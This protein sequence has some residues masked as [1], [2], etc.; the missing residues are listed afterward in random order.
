MGGTARAEDSQG[1]PTQSHISPNI[2]VYEGNKPSEMDQIEAGACALSLHLNDLI[3]SLICVGLGALSEHNFYGFKIPFCTRNPLEGRL[4]KHDLVWDAPPEARGSHN[5]TLHPT[6]YTLHPT[7]Y[8][9]HP[10]PYT[11]H[12]TP[13]T[14]HHAPYTL[15][16][17]P[18]T[19]SPRT[20]KRGTSQH[21]CGTSA[22][23]CNG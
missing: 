17:T 6:P 13:F 9:L 14:L 2:L 8:T 11:L 19:L 22:N 16:P 4:A 7:P 15:H 1:T 21:K 12:P 23:L 18:Y 3:V 5:D 20:P 10:T